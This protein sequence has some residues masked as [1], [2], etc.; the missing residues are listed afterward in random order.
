MQQ[1]RL[2]RSP[3]IG[4]W[5]VFAIA[6]VL[7][8]V[9][10]SA[11]AAQGKSKG[12]PPSTPPGKSKANPPGKSTL[13]QPSSAGLAG[14]ASAPLP[15][16]VPGTS[17]GSPTAW[18]DEANLLPAGSASLAMYAAGWHGASASELDVPVVDAAFG[19]TPRLQIGANV[20]RIVGDAETGT[21]GG[22]GTTY[23]TAK[24]GVLTDTPVKVAVAP[25]L[26]LLG[27]AAREALS[28]EESQLQWGL[29]IIAEIDRGA[30]RVFAST[31]Y[32]A[33]RTWF[34]GGGV[35]LQASPRVGVTV[36]FSRAWTTVDPLVSTGEASTRNEISSA[37]SYAVAPQI[38]VFGSVG[39][40][41]AT[42][43]ENGAGVSVAAGVSIYAKPSSRRP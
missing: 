28:P 17:S 29:P 26:R 14:A 36:S 27:T 34:A 21:A 35:G 9:L 18:I 25:T 42:T 12:N 32:F 2:E 16:G 11:A 33:H 43:D 39:R 4:S 31:G 23:F 19:L 41:I 10:P 40:T 30:G 38:A 37:V 22:L 1:P 7:T 3:R 8:I 20:P 15:V 24:I 6:A 5:S 13:P